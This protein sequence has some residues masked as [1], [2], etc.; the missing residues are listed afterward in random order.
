MK[1]FSLLF[2]VNFIALTAFAEEALDFYTNE[3]NNALTVVDQLSILRTVRNA[4]LEDSASFYATALKRLL[5]VYPNI[6]EVREVHAADECMRLIAEQLSEA[7]YTEA[8]QD[9]WRAVQVFRNPVVRSDALIALG[10]VGATDL[11]PQ[12]VQTLLD[13]N[14]E[15]SI[16][17]V[18]GERIAYGAI[19]A[20]ESYQD[21]TGY[22]P[23]YFAAHGWY[24]QW[25][26]TQA[27][28]SLPLIAEDPSEALLAV[29]HGPGYAYTYKYLALRSLEASEVSEESKAQAAL[30]ALYEGWRGSTNAPQQIRDLVSM[31]KLAMDMIARY[32]IEDETVYRLLE[33]SYMKGIDDEERIAAIR[34]LSKLGTEEAAGLLSSFIS[35]INNSLQRGILTQRDERMLRVL[36][37][38]LGATGQ[39]VG[40][41]VLQQVLA[42]NWSQGI[43]THAQEALD[44]IGD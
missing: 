44:S 42:L 24:S 31:R 7:Q 29:I 22:L 37:P 38:S 18:S 23:V 6:R 30:A 35:L 9:L 36:L 39:S 32:G 10:K 33:R 13:T 12:V 4:E 25:V 26:R 34:A 43:H 21:P 1:R 3:L 15:P 20:L 27:E 16:N 5:Q 28:T 17:R 41:P 2:L 8:G 40:E 14:A 11:L 19:L